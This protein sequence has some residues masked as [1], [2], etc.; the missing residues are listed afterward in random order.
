MRLAFEG[1]VERVDAGGSEVRVKTSGK[2]RNEAL[3]ERAYVRVT[4][5]PKR[6]E[7]WQF[8]RRVEERNGAEVALVL[9]RPPLRVREEEVVE[10]A[11]RVEVKLWILAQE[12]FDD[13]AVV[14]ALDLHL[15]LG[16]VSLPEPC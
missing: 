1:S 7:H 9:E 5:T 4:I 8:R 3:E 14:E 10:I 16:C 2:D 15:S 11:E 6:E 13:R 12:G